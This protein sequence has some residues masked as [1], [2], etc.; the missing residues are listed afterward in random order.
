MSGR[1]ANGSNGCVAKVRRDE[2]L[3]RGDVT[4][5]MTANELLLLFP[6]EGLACVNV[7][8]ITTELALSIVDHGSAL[9]PGMKQFPGCSRVTQR[10]AR[11]L[12]DLW[13]FV[14]SARD[15]ARAELGRSSGVRL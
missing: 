5:A 10:S 8:K 3:L 12:R 13:G 7:G 4:A 2:R 6:R 11:K 1:L 14:R 9:E 15:Y